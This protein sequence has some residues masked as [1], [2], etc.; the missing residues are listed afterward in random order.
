MLLQKYEEQKMGHKR[1]V[2]TQISYSI[3]AVMRPSTIYRA[4]LTLLCIVALSSCSDASDSK[5]AAPAQLGVEV[6]LDSGVVIGQE[7]AESEV[8]E[9]LGIPY[10]QPPVSELR[11]RA[12]QPI[13][14][15]GGIREATSFGAP[16]PQIRGDAVIGNE[17]CLHLNV[18][19]PR[20]EERGL[21][22]YVWIHGGG[23]RS[24][25]IDISVYQGDRLAMQSNIV[26]VSIQYRLGPLGWL[27]FEPLHSGDPLDDSGNFGLLDIIL[28][29]QWIQN[30]I[31]EFGGDAGNVIITGESAGG[32]NIMSLLLSE[33]AS[34]LFH[35]AIIQSGRPESPSPEQGMVWAAALYDNLTEL[36]GVSPSDPTNEELAQFMR[37][38]SAAELV[39]SFR[40]IPRVYSFSDGTVVPM[41]GIAL[42]ATG[43]YVNKVPIIVGTNRDEF[44]LWTNPVHLNAYPT[45][46]EEVR[47]GLG[48]YVSDMWRVVG[49]DQF[50]TE[51]TAAPDQ[52]DVYVYRFNWG[53]P[54]LEGNSPFPGDYGELLGAHH[55][56]DIAFVLGNW[57]VWLT[58]LG[59]R[60][61]FTEESAAGRQNL[62]EALMKYFA[63]F[64]HSGNPNGSNLPTWEPFTVNGTFKAIEFNV[65]LLDSSAK[66]TVDRETYTVESVL[67][68]IDANLVEPTRSDVLEVL[69]GLGWDTLEPYQP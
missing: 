2:A 14:A 25:S 22:V 54:D 41:E 1:T 31:E 47:A 18:W 39:E 66:F 44:K 3:T 43:E 33:Q 11:W 26:V 15:W 48:R 19:R 24:D 30:N 21:P 9:W 8:W 45:V 63:A 34:G 55:A 61:F 16:C 12:P 35:K 64:A 23:N 36:I 5:T 53:A 67:T 46:T 32:I 42:F 27:Y 69:F 68:D 49:A 10:A 37:D 29:L 28:T 17:D 52:P 58:P 57:E 62:S 6:R 13:D 38:R 51:I 59:T 56:L 40:D 65:D 60:F 7:H 50:A 4:L 20:T